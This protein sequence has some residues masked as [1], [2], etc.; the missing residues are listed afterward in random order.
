MH[1][2]N[3]CYH[4]WT[5]SVLTRVEVNNPGSLSVPKFHV[6]NFLSTHM[7]KWKFGIE[8]DSEV[9]LDSGITENLLFLDKSVREKTSIWINCSIHQPWLHLRSYVI[10]YINVKWKKS[11][12]CSHP[13]SGEKS[14]LLFQIYGK[15]G[16]SWMFPSQLPEP[17][18]NNF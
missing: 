14:T 9:L 11:V 18:E 7:Q 13:S 12:K 3:S 15:M 16:N 8:G 17:N 5:S 2:R 10:C 6:Y 4:V 1:Q